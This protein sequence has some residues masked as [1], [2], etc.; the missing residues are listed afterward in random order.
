MIRARLRDISAELADK[1]RILYGGSLSPKNAD[2]LLR[3][4]D[5]DGG[6]IGGA[7]L[8]SEDFSKVAEIAQTIAG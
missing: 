4:P 5:V 8:K 6:L 3:A 1:T 2:A 7:A